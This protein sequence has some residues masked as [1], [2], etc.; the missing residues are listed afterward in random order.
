[1]DFIA[2]SMS[3]DKLLYICDPIFRIFNEEHLK[4]A[5]VRRRFHGCMAAKHWVEIRWAYLP[6]LLNV[7]LPWNKEVLF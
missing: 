6:Y 3:A 1:M 5:S 4:A 7:H 2:E